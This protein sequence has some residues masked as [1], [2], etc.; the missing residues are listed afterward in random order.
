VP[1]TDSIGCVTWGHNPSVFVDGGC[2][3]LTA[4]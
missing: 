3:E 4:R 1:M 2:S